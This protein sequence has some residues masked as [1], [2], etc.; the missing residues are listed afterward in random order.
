MVVSI[1]FTLNHAAKLR[2]SVAKAKSSLKKS[3][4]FVEKVPYFIP[5]SSIQEDLSEIDWLYPSTN[6]TGVTA[7]HPNA[8]NMGSWQMNPCIYCQKMLSHVIFHRTHIS[9]EAMEVNMGRSRCKGPSVWSGEGT[10]GRGWVWH[11]CMENV[12]LNNWIA[13]ASWSLGAWCCLSST[14]YLKDYPQSNKH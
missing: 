9:S 7:D 12:D 8:G 4:E 11:W 14:Y 3:H 6:I 10:E 5:S 13:W 1:T 2:D